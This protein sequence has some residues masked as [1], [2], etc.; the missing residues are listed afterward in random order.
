MHLR[1]PIFHTV[2][3]SLRAWVDAPPVLL[4]GEGDRSGGR[5]SSRSDYT[6]PNRELTA[7]NQV[8]TTPQGEEICD[9][10]T[11]RRSRRKTTGV[12]FFPYLFW[13]QVLFFV[14]K[15]C[16]NRDTWLIVSG[17]LVIVLMVCK[18]YILSD[19]ILSQI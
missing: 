13:T 16:P 10:T 7:A 17:L 1:H 4:S 12:E 11:L 2:R 15:F 6:R 9:P 5:S 8:R 18:S 3:S 19:T 14:W